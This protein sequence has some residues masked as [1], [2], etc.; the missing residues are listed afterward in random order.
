MT[1]RRLRP[2]QIIGIAALAIVAAASLVI[3]CEQIYWPVIRERACSAMLSLPWLPDAVVGH[4][5]DRRGL[6]RLD[7]DDAAGSLRD[8]EA[9]VVKAPGRPRIHN[10]LGN[11]YRN[12]RRLEDAE[13]AYTRA[14]ALKADYGRTALNR[15]TVR[16]DLGQ[17]DGALRDLDRAVQFQPE[18]ASPLMVRG[19]VKLMLGKPLE[20]LADYDRA[21]GV[22]PESDLWI[23]R[24]RHCVRLA[25]GRLAGAALDLSRRECRPASQAASAASVCTDAAAFARHFAALRISARG[26]ELALS[27]KDPL[28][29]RCA[30]KTVQD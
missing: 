15:A 11:A 16:I 12:L 22:A 3:G 19:N 21:I 18:A 29:I 17:L 30:Y 5:L 4:L 10:S 28:R 26:R 14:L 1:A 8:L 7:L 23:V 20:A 27:I 6:A 9:A 25:M 2:R 24:F 13:A